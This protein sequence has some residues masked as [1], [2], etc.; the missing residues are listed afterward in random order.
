MIKLGSII[1]GRYLVESCLKKGPLNCVYRVSDLRNPGVLLTVKELASAQDVPEYAAA[2]QMLRTEVDL[3]ARLRH[4]GIVSIVDTFVYGEHLCLVTEYLEGVSLH[5]LVREEGPQ[6]EARV[7]EWVHEIAQVLMFLHAQ[8]PPIVYRDMKPAN[9][10][11]LPNGQL[12]LLDLGTA[13]EYKAAGRAHDTVAF[14]TH[15]YAPPEQYGQSQTDIRADV[16]ALGASMWHLLAG[17]VPTAQV[18]LPNICTERR[19]VSA[20]MAQAI[21]RCTQPK[22]QERFANCEELLAFLDAPQEAL[23]ASLFSRL[24]ER[25]LLKKPP[26]GD[27]VQGCVGAAE[28]G[29]VQPQAPARAQTRMGSVSFGMPA[30][31]LAKKNN[32]ADA[33]SFI[34]AHDELVVHTSERLEGE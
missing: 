17:K 4:P 22:R 32:T 2:Q 6:S 16:Y 12:K 3:L 28:A 8:K 13:R 5:Q 34:I 23:K 31:N 26:T 19:D 21:V 9:V 7:R 15:G 11:L 24:S 33:F 30:D 29:G 10:M 27:A 14:G 1:K 18:P 20:Q 25:F